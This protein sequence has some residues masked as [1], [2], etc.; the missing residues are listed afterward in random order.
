MLGSAVYS[1]KYT[2]LFYILNLDSTGGTSWRVILALSIVLVAF[3]ILVI[4]VISCLI[5]VIVLRKAK[6]KLQKEL[7]AKTT[8]YEEI[9][10]VNEQPQVDTN[11]NIAYATKK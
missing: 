9:E 1:S 8:I 11:D 6:V 4:I 5:A 3:L 2:S 7:N 10:I